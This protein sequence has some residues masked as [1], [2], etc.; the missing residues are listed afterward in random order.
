LAVLKFF[1]ALKGIAIIH[2]PDVPNSR[3]EYI[4]ITSDGGINWNLLDLAIIPYCD[5]LFFVD[6]IVFVAGENQKIFKSS[7][8]GSI[9]VI[10]DSGEAFGKPFPASSDLPLKRFEKV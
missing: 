4:A 10:L 6:N 8:I 2:T 1:D 9:S 5:K 3:D 7:A